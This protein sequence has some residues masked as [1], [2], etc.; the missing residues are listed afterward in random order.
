MTPAIALFT[1]A[2]ILIK[3]GIDNVSPWDVLRGSKKKKAGGEISP[4][5]SMTTYEDAT[6]LDTQLVPAPGRHAGTVNIDGKPV[7]LWIV[8]YVRWARKH[9][10]RGVV[11]SGYRTTAQQAAV[12]STYGPK[13]KPGTSN[14]ERTLFPG[15]AIDVTDPDGFAQALRSFP[16][17]VPLKQ[18]TAIGDP[19]HFSST[20]H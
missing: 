16:G 18:G 19:I 5:A 15:G 1:I 13:A 4:F 12:K 6:N 20:G 2:L 11:T 9:G 10:W 7:A 3:S 8:P 17:P 14:H